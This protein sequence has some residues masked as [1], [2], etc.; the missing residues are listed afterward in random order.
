M[1][2]YLIPTGLVSL[3]VLLIASEAFVPSA[4]ILGILAIASLAGG[5]VMAYYYGGLV[6]GTLFMVVTGVI[7]SALIMK[8]IRWWP[9]S[10]IGKLMLVEPAKEE[11]LLVD[12]SETQSMVGRVGKALGLMMPGGLIEI[13]GKRMEA[14]A[15]IA[16]E[17][18]S[19]VEVT[20]ITS[21]RIL[22]V[23]PITEEQVKERNQES[24]S[25]ESPLSKPA[26]D[27]L[28][29]PFEDALG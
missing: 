22:N 5:V 9:E 19:W 20:K 25:D 13:D 27:I 8:M 11:D 17:E 3:G 15:E 21:G 1:R 26:K 10:T 28:D 16:I 29:D 14:V 2:E 7:V 6:V 4:G 24:D 12:R 23:R 18:G